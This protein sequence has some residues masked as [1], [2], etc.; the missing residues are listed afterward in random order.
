[1]FKVELPLQKIKVD[2]KYS[3]SEIKN[4]QGVYRGTRVG[5]GY[6]ITFPIGEGKEHTSIFVDNENRVE[7]VNDFSWKDD[8]FIEMKLD[9]KVVLS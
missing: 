9:V 6:I 2:R 7:S 1:M 4:R 3:L 8:H 5:I